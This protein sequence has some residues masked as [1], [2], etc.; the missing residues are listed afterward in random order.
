MLL[1]RENE[2]LRRR[3]DEMEKEIVALRT[4]AGNHGQQA[5]GQGEGD[6][7]P[8]QTL[9]RATKRHFGGSSITSAGADPLKEQKHEQ[10]EEHAQCY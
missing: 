1:A 5:Q 9:K 4:G 3:Q 6:V 2:R 10:L 7:G 8:V